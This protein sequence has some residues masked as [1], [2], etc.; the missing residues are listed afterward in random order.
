MKTD[1]RFRTALRET[2][3]RIGGAKIV[4]PALWPAID[5]EDAEQRCND[6]CNPLRREK[7]SIEELVQILVQAREAGVHDAM[8]ALCAECGYAAPRTT[9]APEVSS[10][11]SIPITLTRIEANSAA[12]LKLL[13]RMC[14]EED[15]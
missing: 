2:V 12:M 1:A 10:I 7:F 8:K 14:G 4:G 11:S 5:A 6:R 13:A 9:D 3:K 15:S